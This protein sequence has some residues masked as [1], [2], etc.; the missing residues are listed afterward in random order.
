MAAPLPWAL[1]CAAEFAYTFA[2][3][4]GHLRVARLPTSAGTMAASARF[5]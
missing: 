4:A 1:L 5:F 2:V 3:N